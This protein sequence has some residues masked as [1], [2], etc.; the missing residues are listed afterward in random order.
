MITGLRLFVASWFFVATSWVQAHPHSWVNLTAEFEINEQGELVG[1]HQRW[2]FDAFYSALTI[3]DLQSEGS[4]FD[5]ALNGLKADMVFHL[6]NVGYYSHLQV[7]KEAK[8]LGFPNK[9]DLYTVKAAD[10]ELLILEFRWALAATELAEKTVQWQ[11]FDPTFYVDMRYD[12]VEQVVINNRSSNECQ[13]TLIESNPTD[14]QRAY[15]ASLD[16]SQ[17]ETTGLGQLFAQTVTVQCF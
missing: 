3:A 7:G 9:S 8:A 16:K 10:Q 14:E 17:T 5:T 2:I 12:S 13:P 6:N 15:A 1:V 11:V 4:D